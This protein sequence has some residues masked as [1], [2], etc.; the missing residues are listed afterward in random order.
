MYEAFSATPSVEE[1]RTRIAGANINE[2][3]LLAT[4][5]LNHFN[6][7]AMILEMLPDMPDFVED[8]KSWSLKSYKQHFMDSTFSDKELAIAAYDCV[9]TTY[10][11]AFESAIDYIAK[12]F[13]DSIQTIETAI[14]TSDRDRIELAT[15]DICE[16]IKASMSTMRS[17][18]NGE[19]S[20][21]EQDDIDQML[22][23]PLEEAANTAPEPAV[24]EAE[25]QETGALDKNSIDSL[26]D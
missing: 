4:D 10:L 7:V 23:D 8:V 9:P 21:F 5:Y 19:L 25:T 16:K 20:T 1:M 26:F 14:E 18:V 6:E 24:D 12:L 2:Q 3:S 13:H 22:S 15:K 17:I 11:I